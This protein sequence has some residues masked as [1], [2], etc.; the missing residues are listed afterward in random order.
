MKSGALLVRCWELALADFGRDLP[1]AT[2]WE[3]A[4]IFFGQA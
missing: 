2:A 4:E 3:P 1:V